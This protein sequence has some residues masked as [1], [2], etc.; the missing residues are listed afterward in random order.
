MSTLL[1]QIKERVEGGLEGVK[2]EAKGENGH[3]DVLVVGECF[4]EK[5]PV[6][7]QKM[8]YA[9]LNDKINSGE[10]HAITIKAYTPEQWEKA[11]QLQVGGG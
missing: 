10:I 7:R 1:E 11:R 4:A 5:N 8:V 9:T 3:F 6:Q 2:A